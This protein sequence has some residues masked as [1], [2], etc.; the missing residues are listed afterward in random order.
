MWLFLRNLAVNKNIK[1]QKRD[2]QTITFKGFWD[3]FM[4]YQ[5][6]FSPQFKECANVADKYGISELPHVLPNNLTPRI[7]IN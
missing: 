3:F 2:L 7:L 6:L 5:I 1:N 4:F